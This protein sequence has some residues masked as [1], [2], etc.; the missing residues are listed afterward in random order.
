MQFWAVAIFVDFY[1]V[2]FFVFQFKKIKCSIREYVCRDRV[3]EGVV[4]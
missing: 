2:D 1:F 4:K 3:G